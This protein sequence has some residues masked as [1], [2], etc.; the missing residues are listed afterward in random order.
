M[1]LKNELDAM[2]PNGATT[3]TNTIKI[4]KSGIE[5]AAALIKSGDF[6]G[7]A[8]EAKAS[9]MRSFDDAYNYNG[10]VGLNDEEVLTLPI[11]YLHGKETSDLTHDVIGSL[12]AYADM[13][14]NF[15]AMQEIINPLE[16]GKNWVMDRRDI[17]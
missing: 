8:R 6:K 1:A 12:I 7:L 2:L 16:I 17:G 13:A 10:L 3:L 14:Y 15:Q 5:R 11:Y 9:Y 4:R